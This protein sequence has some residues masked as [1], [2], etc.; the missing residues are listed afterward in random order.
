MLFFL[1]GKLILILWLCFF[2]NFRM[3]FLCNVFSSQLDLTKKD[4]IVA[5]KDIHCVHLL[6]CIHKKTELH[7][8]QFFKKEKPVFKRFFY[9]ASESTCYALNIVNQENNLQKIIPVHVICLSMVT[10]ITMGLKGR[11]FFQTLQISLRKKALYKDIKKHLNFTFK[12]HRI[13]LLY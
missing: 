8:K 5:V 10:C 6:S 1:M 12:I 2:Q 7:N 13:F 9:K 3:S 11:G 4:H